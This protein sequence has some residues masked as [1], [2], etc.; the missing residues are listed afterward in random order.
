MASGTSIV[1]DVS[2][3]DQSGIGITG[4]PSGQSHGTVTA[5]VNN[6]TVT[7]TNDGGGATSD[8]FTFLDDGG[9]TV[10][11]NV[12]IGAPT[13]SIV[14]NPAVLPT[15]QVGTSYTQALSGSGGIAPY[16][17]ALISGAL[18]SG[19]TLSNGTISGTPNQAGSYSF[20]IRATDNTSATGTRAY[21]VTVPNPTS[22]MSTAA[23][24]GATLNTPYS[25]QLNTTGA[26]APYTYLLESGTLPTGVS[27][28]STGLLSGTPTVAGT[29]NFS[30]RATDASP[31]PNGPYFKVTALT[32]V[33]SN[34]PPVAGN[35]SAPVA[36][37]STANPITLNLSG[38]APTSVAVATPASHGTA[39]AS[40][41]TIT[42]TPTTGYAGPDSFTYT[43]TNGGGTSAPGTVS[44]TVN[45]ATIA[46]AP[47]SPPNGTRGVAYSQSLASASG[48]AAPY[49]YAVVSGSLPPGL[50]LGATSGTLT[51][52]PTTAGPYNFIV[53]ATDSST[54]TGP[55]SQSS[56]TLSLTITDVPAAPGITSLTASSGQV[57]VGVSPPASNG[58]SAITGYTV[59]ASPGGVTGTLSGPAGGNVTVTGLSNG[60]S[61]SFTATATNAVG[62]GPASAAA[63]PVTPLANQTITFSPPGTQNYGTTPTLTA[64]SSSGLAVTWS[65][66]TPAVCSIGT[67]SGTLNFLS[68]GN[69]TINADQAGNGTYSAAPRVSQT[70]T[71]NAVAPGA[72]T[73]G[74]ATAGNAQ[75]SV[76]FTAPANTGGAAITGYTV[77]SNPGNVTATGATSPVTITGLTNG[78]AYIFTVTATNGQTGSASAASNSV[79]PRGTQTITFA[80]PGNVNFGASTTL[81]ATASSG[82]PVI[83]TSTTPSVCTVS[84]QQL[85]AVAPGNCVIDANQPGN[86]AFTP[87]AQ[88]VQSFNVV[89]PG[90]AVSIATTTLPPATGG[91]AYSQTIVANGGFQP[92][93]FSL[94]GG[95]L[96]SGIT[97]TSAGSIVGTPTVAGTFPLTVRVTDAATQTAD[98]ALT[99]IVNAP[100]ITI[101][102]PT[103]PAATANQPYAQTLSASG[104]TAAYTFAVTSGALPSGLTLA[105]SGALTGT[106]TT[107][108]S[109]AF[110]ITATDVHGFTGAR[111][112]TLVTG[113]PAPV[114]VN[115]AATVGANVTA[116]LPVTTN[117]SG[118]ITSIAIGQAPAHGT[119]TVNGLN[120]SYAPAHDY[121]GTDSFTYT[122]TGPGGTS[123]A[124]TV[125]VT[126]TPGA[127]PVAQPKSATVLAGKTVTIHAAEGA[128]NGPFTLL[129]IVSQPTSGSVT[130][131]GTDAVYTAAADASGQSTFDY[132]LSNAFG[133][134]APVR[135]TLDVDPMPVAPALTTAA[136][137]GTSV[138][139]DLTTGARGGPFTA[140]NLVAM[141]PANAGSASILTTASGFS[142]SF[143]A[144]PAFSGSARLSYT[145]T[146]AYATSP[147]GTIT[148]TVTQ[149]SDPSKDAEVVGLLS[150]QADAAR[151]MATGQ[152]SNFQRRLEMLHGDGLAGFSNGLTFSSAGSQRGKDAYADLRKQSDDTSRRYLVQPDPDNA[153]AATGRSGGSLPGD[154]SVWTGGAVNFGRSQPGA[155]GNGTDFTTSGVSFGVDKRFSS[156]FAMG[157]GVGYGHD[158]SD[159][160]DNGTHSSVD[161]Y[162]V[163]LYASYHPTESFYTDALIGYQW[164]SFDARRYLTDDGG[165]VHG[166][167]DGKQLFGSFS[168]G[169]LYQAD[170]TQL[171]PY[172]RID[173]AHARLDGYTERGDAL[174]ALA[175]QSQTVKTSTATIGLLAQWTAKRDYGVWAP[176]LRAEFG[177]D[178]QGASQASMRYADL[179]DGP[180]YR[181]TLQQQ[182]RE[183][184]LLGAGVALQTLRGWILRAEYQLQLDNTSRDNQSIL[185][186]V[187]KKFDP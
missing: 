89:V 86:A 131:Q 32:V 158:S 30:V 79:T 116:T 157:A 63:G 153:P 64:T 1:I 114:S 121:F 39:T 44:V 28:S 98:Q 119:A 169:Y 159:V 54:G 92:Y 84:G 139:V 173:I 136:I 8:S 151:R 102:P 41:T 138:T 135:A 140:A 17:F 112:Y 87:A 40:G 161:S 88:V 107:A 67:T 90:G 148:V 74:T 22:G 144:N 187:E 5:N 62:T 97:F 20:T 109:A 113:Q 48:G 66:S 29:F 103:L 179:L 19:L 81:N 42:Y 10:R 50:S 167:R 166:T 77:T 184:T 185:I 71:V 106:P 146:N 108:A 11:V 13:S 59:T 171:T 75:A 53:R 127:V 65:S 100:G 91:V 104:G 46:Y 27:L 142:L 45:A 178:M 25:A 132:T 125:S 24:P 130:V 18:P 170:G 26:L 93:T 152:I 85:T 73:I 2:A 181:A 95:A 60:T 34:N 14:V 105:P 182:S 174:Y 76:G 110:S 141:E 180:L 47:A 9:A 134:S 177:H 33:V 56:S 23:P 70:F 128:T 143:T 122:A 111:A 78:T 4:S 3:C 165:L 137:A 124:A 43:A 156:S 150:A 21:S 176:Q 37:G 133:A 36:Y 83:L 15:P 147:A 6:D 12:T 129:T 35:V 163:A 118:P 120:V 183:H 164:L 80:N 58:G 16:T 154:V 68:A 101:S 115:D 31:G 168:V 55:F 96:P 172:G 69:C 117:D 99:L 186:G 51:G 155:S 61:Y 57:V 94:V 7:Y 49:T 145:L 126:V 123:A 162:N 82:L 175:Y 149:R 38:G 160:G 52:T 72:P